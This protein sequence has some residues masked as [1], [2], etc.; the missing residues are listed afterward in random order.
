MT[1]YEILVILSLI[2]WI[3]LSVT[4]IIGLLRLL[5]RLINALRQ[6]ESMSDEFLKKAVPVLDQSQQ[7]LDQVGGVAASLADDVD[8]IDRTVIRATSSVESMVEL[9]EDRVSEINALLEVAVE[10]AEETFFSTAA[11]M[12][13]LRL[14]GRGRKSRRRSRTER[15]RLG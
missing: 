11:I 3:L 2:L 15:R 12:R 9:A 4:L 1:F 14:G 10:E 7:L 13:A 8:R 5:P 6:L